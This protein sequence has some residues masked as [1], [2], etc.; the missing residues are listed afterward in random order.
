MSFRPFLLA[1]CLLTSTVFSSQV[2]ADTAEVLQAFTWLN[3]DDY[4]GAKLKRP[5]NSRI[6]AVYEI[7]QEDEDER[8]V[9]RLKR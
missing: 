3:D 4:I 6:R 9:H 1:L 8:E 5:M 7:L 2:W